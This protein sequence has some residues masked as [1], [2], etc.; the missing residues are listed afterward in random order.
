MIAL[1][2]SLR[3]PCLLAAVAGV[4]F[5]RSA[6]AQD[7][8]MIVSPSGVMLKAGKPYRSIGGNAP[9]D[10]YEFFEH[11]NSAYL[12]TFAN[13]KASGLDFVR[14]TALGWFPTEQLVTLYFTDKTTYFQKMDQIVDAAAQNGVGICFGLTWWINCMSDYFG[15]PMLAST[16]PGSKTYMGMQSLAIDFATHYKNNPAV[17][18]YSDTVELN[19]SADQPNSGQP[20]NERWTIEGV[21]T[22]LANISGAI[23]SVDPNRCI[24]AG[25]G[26]ARGDQWHMTNYCLWNPDTPAQYARALA[27]AN[28]D[29]VDTLDTHYY[30]SGGPAGSGCSWGV[31]NALALQLR[32]PVY[33]E[34]FGEGGGDTSQVTAANFNF[35]LSDLIANRVPLMSEWF[36]GAPQVPGTDDTAPTGTWA[37]MWNA[38]AQAN[39]QYKFGP[40]KSPAVASGDWN[41]AGN[42]ASGTVP[43]TADDVYV[44][45][46]GTTTRSLSI[47]GTAYARNLAIGT[48]STGEIAATININGSGQLVL[49]QNSSLTFTTTT[50][51]TTATAI[52]VNG[53]HGQFLDNSSRSAILSINQSTGATQSAIVANT[54]SAYRMKTGDRANISAE[55]TQLNLF[56]GMTVGGV[57]SSA[58]TV[59]QTGGIVRVGLDAT[60]TGGTPTGLVFNVGSSAPKVVLSSGTLAASGVTGT[61]GA[62]IDWQGGTISTLDGAS[63]SINSTLDIQLNGTG[64]HSIYVADR[65]Q[66]ITVNTAADISGSG[67]LTK[68]GPGKLVL[69]GAIAQYAYTGT[70]TI[71][72]G[73]LQVKTRQ[74]L[75][76]WNTA[77]KV[78]VGARLSGTSNGVVT[79]GT[80]AFNVGGTGEWRTSDITTILSNNRITFGDG[81]ALGIDTSNAA[82][83]VTLTNQLTGVKG[84]TKLG[85]GTLTLNPGS[86][87]TFTGMTTVMGG[88]LQL[89]ATSNII[90][91][92]TSGFDVQ[93]GTLDL[94]GKNVTISVNF[95]ALTDNPTNPPLPWL[96]QPARV[97]F[98]GGLVQNGTITNNTFANAFGGMFDGQSGTVSANLAGS[99]WLW[100]TTQGTLTLTGSNSYTGS[101]RI[102]KGTL[103]LGNANALGA[104]G[105]IIFMNGTL[106]YATGVTTDYSSRF[107]SSYSAINIDTNGQTITFASP[108]DSSN[109]SGLKKSGSG[110]LILSAT[111]N[112]YTGGTWIDQGTLQTSVDA[113]LSGTS[114]NDLTLC[115]GGIFDLYG[116]TQTVGNLYSL[117]TG[118]VSIVNNKSG[119][120]ATLAIGGSKTNQ[121]SGILS[122]HSTGTGTLALNLV[123]SGEKILSG[124]NITY[125]G[126]TVISAGILTLK[127]T[128][129]FTGNITNNATLNFAASSGSNNVFS[130]AISGT[131][132]L[133][134]AGPGTVTLSGNYAYSGITILAG[135]IL[136]IAHFTNYG[137][138]GGLGNR[139]AD[140]SQ[141]VGILFRSGTLQYTGSTAQST[142]RAIRVS[143]SG[144][145][146]DASGSNPSATLSFTATSSPNFLENSGA[147]AVTFTGTNTGNNTFGMAIGESGGQTSVVKNGTGT[148]VLGG[149]NS[150]TGATNV[151]AGTL[152]VSGTLNGNSAVTVLPSAT[153]TGNGTVKGAV[154]INSGATIAPGDSVGTLTTGSI[155]LSGT[156]ACE[157]DGAVADRITSTGDLTISS[158]ATLAFSILNAP[159]LYSYVIASWGGV[160]SGT[161]SNVTGKPVGYDLVYDSVLKQIRLDYTNTWTGSINSNWDTTTA[162]WTLPTTWSNGACAVFGTGTFTLNVLGT[163]KATNIT[164]LDGT[165]T[166]QIGAGNSLELLNANI[167]ASPWAKITGSGTLSIGG[168]GTVT[169][170]TASTFSGTL[171]STGGTV[172]F[173]ALGSTVALVMNGGNF[174]YTGVGAT[175]ASLA[176]LQSG[177]LSAPSG[178]LTVGVLTGS[179]ALSVR[180]SAWQSGL[181]LSGTANN[182]FSGTID[183]GT[184]LYYGMIYLTHENS[185]GTNAN[186]LIAGNGT[187]LYDNGSPL[188][189]AHHKITVPGSIAFVANSSTGDMI[190]T[191]GITGAG[192][193]SFQSNPSRAVVLGGTNDYAGTTYISDGNTTLRLGANNALPFGTGKGNLVFSVWGPG[194]ST[195]DLAGFNQTLNGFS[196]WGNGSGAKII[197]N[198]SA[199]GTVTLTVGAAN[200]VGAFAGSIRNTTGTLNLGKIGTG[201]LTLSGS[202]TYTGNTT[203]SSGTLILADN[204]QLKFVTG[205]ASGVNNAISGAGTAVLNGDYVIDT[206]ATDASGLV[207]GSWQIENVVSCT[208]G[209]T[210]TVVGW[211][212]AGSNKW[213]KTVGTKDYSFDE[214]TGVV[215]L[216]SSFTSWIAAHGLT[217]ATAAFDADPDRDGIPNG[218]EFA[219]GG[220]PNPANAGANSTGLL[221]AASTASGNLVFSF[222]RKILSESTVTLTFQWSTD[223]TF[224]SPANDIPVGTASSVTN[225]V[226]VAITQGVPDSLTDTVVITVPAAKAAGGK[227]FGRLKAVQ[228]Q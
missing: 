219:L 76:G 201:T 192:G 204:A 227:L 156:Y 206:T 200:A 214:S 85:T 95:S 146:I 161:F 92:E 37:Y 193:V 178:L 159:T 64:T 17:I 154:A 12:Q 39:A 94:G 163:I 160:L 36:I 202:N 69:T 79:A 124:S 168:P 215:T 10:T 136:N 185:L 221:P 51:G 129:N 15:E 157:I 177:T 62:V 224:P 86:S 131:G 190:I 153:L 46:D 218:L 107:K 144:A 174:T 115:N 19:L 11:N 121:F 9:F 118:T 48:G 72:D 149:S 70:T 28:P 24:H 105:D 113:A 182:G 226:N 66:S 119:T 138:P 74:A 181:V 20:V 54:V 38:L 111:N 114:V 21:Q 140:D 91:P 80:V 141:N 23:R 220:E 209:S 67:N 7:T 133:S 73:I 170:G 98:A 78:F 102:S 167:S 212:D 162:N 61:T 88:T 31:Y 59:Y 34:E 211:T 169:L 68:D 132:S 222:K 196:D 83:T 134:A 103:I 96:T 164:G 112:S 225:G 81:S 179:G 187:W 33:A 77:N 173:A 130:G 217:G 56:D 122:D 189:I 199:G 32:K 127:D 145:T 125:T 44:L 5:A 2:R 150:Y 158:S 184:N 53:A 89:G 87:N 139:V 126:P 148:W 108:I 142:N 104:T 27:D 188:T 41:S 99:A 195:L 52:T 101:T 106:K 183:V 100:K 210:F 47:A 55:T 147:R 166:I 30:P 198:G 84:I 60:V 93:G 26:N 120:Q 180:G 197:D 228:A 208:Y 216:S 43:T 58:P 110:T 82:G 109:G 137:V 165:D 1:R 123:G 65:D 143:T 25:S 63:M 128:S 176:V 35:S 207:S 135:G 13:M 45:T 191:G 171:I 205:T 57:S 155:T 116:T 71:N 50:D 4:C 16:V 117:G 172:S 213:T 194:S 75:P 3:I 18:C 175:V 40:W 49:G 42:W 22:V 223:L 186:A 14:L 6:V 151:N 97:T 203:V 8:G 152:K 29:P 90:I